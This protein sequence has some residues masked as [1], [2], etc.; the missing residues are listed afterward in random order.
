M[1]TFPPL[2][3]YNFGL[4]RR[5]LSPP[6][7]R[8][9]RPPS[10]P[11]APALPTARARPT[12]AARARRPSSCRACSP[13]LQLPCAPAPLEEDGGGRSRTDANDDGDERGLSWAEIGTKTWAGRQLAATW[14]G[15]RLARTTYV[16]MARREKTRARSVK[17]IQM[18]GPHF[19]FA[20][21]KCKVPWS[22]TIFRLCK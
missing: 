12:A 10:L 7:L 13:S 20:K 3:I 21:S 16:K 22:W 5:T 15:R 1:Q 14:P 19:G 9:A 6:T 11:R 8:Y 2:C 4:P 17:K 18:W